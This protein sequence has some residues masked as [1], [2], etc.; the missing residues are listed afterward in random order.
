MDRAHQHKLE[1]SWRGLK[2]EQAISWAPGMRTSNNY[3]IIQAE[4]LAAICFPDDEHLVQEPWTVGWDWVPD[5]SDPG[6]VAGLLAQVRE[7][8]KNEWLTPTPWDE[9]F[10]HDDG[11][12]ERGWTFAHTHMPEIRA[13][14]E[15]EACISALEA[16]QRIDRHSCN[17][18]PLPDSVVHILEP[19]D[20]GYVC[21]G[22]EDGSCVDPR[23]WPDE[24]WREYADCSGCLA[25]MTEAPDV[26]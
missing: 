5:F 1:G 26:E 4:T 9:C 23:L 20:G 17:R 8:Y 22:T 21:G 6:T 7:K 11:S 13:R 16:F 24:G 2:K 3:R 25:K 14:S 18:S 10:I 12:C 15:A 19:V